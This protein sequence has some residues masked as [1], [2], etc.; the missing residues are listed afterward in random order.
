MLALRLTRGARPAVQLRRLLVALASAGTGFLLLCTLG[1]AMSH[2]ED[3]SGSV[4]RLAW[5]LTPL[6]A[7]VHLAL[8][9]ARTDPGT[10]PRPGLAAIGLGPARLMAVSAATT[11]LSCLL[12]SMLALLFFLHLRGDLTGLP[13][14]GAAADF[15]AAG[16]PLPLP[17]ALT[18]LALVPAI[19]S[20]TVG[21]VLRPR[22][23]RPA[24]A[25]REARSYG[26]FGAYGRTTAREPFGAYGRFRA[27]QP[28]GGPKATEPTPPG[29]DAPTATALDENQ[30]PD[31]T[32]DT[33][34][35]L[36]QTAPRGLPWGVAVLAAGLAV[37]AYA[38]RHGTASAA[39][40]PAGLTGAPSVLVGWLLTAVGLAVA[41]PGL[42]H[43]CGRLLQST[44]PGA[45]RLLA[46]RVLMAEATRIGRPLGVVCAVASGTYAMVML[47]DPTGPDVGPL[48]TLGLLLVTGCALA[49]LLT[50][51]VEAK[52]ARSDTTAAL[53]RL[54]A[55][56]T[57]LRSA[58]ALRAGAL[59]ALFGPLTLVVA[60][61]AALPLA[62]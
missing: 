53:L 52:Q 32:P 16:S 30:P 48:T 24:S 37:E 62:P 22:D 60:E 44:R 2:P 29:E 46:G 55:P 59:L 39:P 41:G 25:K 19:A 40:L 20:V 54:G 27:R 8:A 26:R 47:Y 1:H 42:T 28:A 36:P 57:M 13:F 18:L 31:L 3:P 6:A 17:A 11:A 56:A 50:A 14:D 10:R 49:T 35:S 58:A 4:L 15:L 61:L 51:A 23:D 33:F 7:T 5:C 38:N 43:L 12:G 34:P 9:V 21:F 45:L